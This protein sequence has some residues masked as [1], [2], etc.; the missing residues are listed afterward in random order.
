MVL[1][2]VGRLGSRHHEERL[3]P[4]KR[5][6]GGIRVGISGDVHL[7]SLERGGTRNVA[8]E[9]TLGDA[10]GGE[11]TRDPTPYG[12]GGSGDGDDGRRGHS[13]SG[14]EWAVPPG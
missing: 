5:R 6:A 4:L 7:G 12:S 9:Q 3:D 8:D 13:A 1:D 2:A 14:D 11:V 10:A